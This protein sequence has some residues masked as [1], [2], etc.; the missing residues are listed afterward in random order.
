MRCIFCADRVEGGYPAE[1]PGNFMSQQWLQAGDGIC[2]R[3]HGFLKSAEV[4]RNSWI[5]RGFEMALDHLEP[6][7]RPLETILDPPEPPFRLYLT[8][9]KRKHGWIRLLHNPALSR[10]CF[11]VSYE[12]DLIRVNIEKVGE[13]YTLVSSLMDRGVT[14]RSLREGLTPYEVKKRN[15]TFQEVKEVEK[16]RRDP[17]WRLV[18]DFAR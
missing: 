10:I 2:V 6:L 9:M 15:I 5:I 16:N 13:H 8:R 18:V 11:P 14:K 7:K 1:L 3:C 12:E 17:L 4:R